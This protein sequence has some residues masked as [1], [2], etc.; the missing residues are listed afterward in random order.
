MAQVALYEG[1]VCCH[2]SSSRAA[3][4]WTLQLELFRA[5]QSPCRVGDI[6]RHG[7]ERSAINAQA[8]RTTPTAAPPR[9]LSSTGLV[10]PDGS[11]SSLE[12]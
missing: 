6:A 12:L 10:L 7:K 4:T 11:S 9:H 5:P 2:Y 3:R 8:R 1:E